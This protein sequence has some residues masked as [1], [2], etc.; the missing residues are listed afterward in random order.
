MFYSLKEGF[1][2]LYRAKFSSLAAISIISLSLIIIG[3]FLIFIQN[4]ERLVNSIQERIELEVFI[5]NSYEIEDTKLQGYLKTIQNRIAAMSHLHELLYKQENLHEIQTAVYF[6]I[7]V[8]EL[9]ESYFKEIDIQLKISVDLE[10]E[11]AIYGG[12]I[13]NEL[14]TNSLKYAF[15]EDSEENKIVIKL[16]RKENKN[17]LEVKDNGKGYDTTKSS[18]SL[19]LTLVETLAVQQLGGEYNIDTSHGTRTIIEWKQY[20]Q[21]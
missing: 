3:V 1:A 6:Q 11:E 9:Q 16:Y 2:G 12:L 4:L 5:D 8:D 13:V 14:V 19:G 15:D 21:D 7:I 20:G 17:Y 18:N 10:T